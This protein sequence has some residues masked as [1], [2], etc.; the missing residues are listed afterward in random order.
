MNNIHE[1]LEPCKTDYLF[2]LVGTNP[3][4]NYVAAR[5]LARPKG[6]I[7]LLHSRTTGDIAQNLT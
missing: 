7:Y 1:L 6:K 3:L 2:L 5:L 4:P